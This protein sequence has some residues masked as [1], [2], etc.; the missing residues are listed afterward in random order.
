MKEVA[1]AAEVPL[2]TY[3]EWEY[4]RAVQGEPYLKIAKALSVSLSELLVGSA[5]HSEAWRAL[6]LVEQHVKNLRNVLSSAL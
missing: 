1:A 5:E 4:G 3:R 2:S 6:E